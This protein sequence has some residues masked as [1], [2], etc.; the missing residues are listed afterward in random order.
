[1]TFEALGLSLAL[2]A[3]VL[4][5]IAAPLLRHKPRFADQSE[6]ISIERLGVHYERVLTALRDLEEDYSVGKLSKARYTDEREHWVAQ[7]IEILAELDRVGALSAADQTVGELDAAVDHQI[8][9][10]VAAYRK[11]H[12]MA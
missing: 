5:W 9:K 6:A 2:V 3:V 1:M 7:G 4:L 11:T 10:A 8:E 12:K